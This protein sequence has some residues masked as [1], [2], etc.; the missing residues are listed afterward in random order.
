M[1][2]VAILDRSAGN[3]SVGD[4]WKETAVFDESVTA[5]EIL[6][7]AS[8]RLNRGIKPEEFRANLRLSVAQE[9]TNDPA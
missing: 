5:R 7:W 4:M 9:P 3:D 2:I 8:K 1:K 6:E